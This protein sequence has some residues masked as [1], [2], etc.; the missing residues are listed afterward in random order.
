M[1][2]IYNV[3]IIIEFNE[4]LVEIINRRT[5]STSN[6]RYYMLLFNNIINTGVCE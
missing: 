4:T 5:K 6:T 2:V 3:S 1:F